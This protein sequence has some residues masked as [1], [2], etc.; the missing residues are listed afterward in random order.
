LSIAVCRKRRS[1]L[2]SL[3]HDATA[4]SG[5]PGTKLLA[6]AA[7]ALNFVDSTLPAGRPQGLAG[8]LGTS[9]F[10]RTAIPDL[11]CEIDPMIVADDRVVVHLRFRGHFT[12]RFGLAA[13]VE[14]FPTLLEI[15]LCVLG[16]W[17]TGRK[18]AT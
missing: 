16:S 13:P 18:H 14:L 7:L 11:S 10:V 9:K 3:R 5:I 12:G 8:P 1:K 2:K 4:R 15:T 17:V 6:R